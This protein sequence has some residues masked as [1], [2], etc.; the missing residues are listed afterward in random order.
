MATGEIKIFD[1]L[2]INQNI[3]CSV[4]SY[5]GVFYA[6]QADIGNRCFYCFAAFVCCLCT[7]LFFVCTLSVL[8]SMILYAIE[9]G[10]KKWYKFK[11]HKLHLEYK[12]KMVRENLSPNNK[13][14]DLVKI[15]AIFK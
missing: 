5:A 12:Q 14:D 15:D 2:S 7:V 6:A 8:S 1:K 13:I 4:I 3:L 11:S 9:Y 10:G